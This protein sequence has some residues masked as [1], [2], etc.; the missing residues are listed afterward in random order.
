MRYNFLIVYIYLK[1]GICFRQVENTTQPF[2]LLISRLWP[3]QH[4][5]F[6]FW[7]NVNVQ[8]PNCFT[9]HVIPKKKIFPTYFLSQTGLQKLMPVSYCKKMCTTYSHSF[10][11]RIF[12]TFL[13]SSSKFLMIRIKDFGVCSSSVE[14]SK[15]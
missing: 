6:Q 1:T 9:I 2:V 3:H 11:F 8:W 10:S 5:T 12:A 4:S 14:G 7:L 15:A 13:Y